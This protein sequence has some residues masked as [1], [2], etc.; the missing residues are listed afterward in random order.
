MHMVL[1][2]V[3]MHQNTL[4]R[5]LYLLIY[6]YKPFDTSNIETR[7]K[8]YKEFF[9]M[10]FGLAYFLTTNNCITSDTLIF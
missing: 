3:N 10:R 5:F 8:M 4:G 9:L 7:S 6:L 2:T 1:S